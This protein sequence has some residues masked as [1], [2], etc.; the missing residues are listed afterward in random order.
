LLL[1]SLTGSLTAQT[2]VGTGSIVGT[3]ND[4]SGTV[5]NR[6]E[7]TIT[8]IATQQVIKVITNP[9][10]SFDSGPLVTGNY[11]T[12]VLAKGFNSTETVLTVLLGNTATLNVK[13]KIGNGKEV[14]KVQD[15][16]S[17]GEYGAT[18]SARR[19]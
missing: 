13:L 16:A 5:I 1:L 7:I 3:V 11:K 19:P 6:A 2:T 4:P 10:G 14:I 8:N 15:S 17:A 12:C 18:H 9:S